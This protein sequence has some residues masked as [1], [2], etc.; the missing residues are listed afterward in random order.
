[1]LYFQ[2]FEFFGHNMEL[3]KHVMSYL[4]PQDLHS[5]ATTSKDML[6]WLTMDMVVRSLLYN[7]TRPYDSVKA[8]YPHMVKRSIYPMSP[9]RVLMICIAKRCEHCPDTKDPQLTNCVRQNFGVRACW[10]CL[11]DKHPD[12][13][14]LDGNPPSQPIISKFWR[15]RESPGQDGY[16]HNQYYLAHRTK[17]YRLFSHPRIL[18]YP[19]GI[20][21]HSLVNGAFIP[22]HDEPDGSY[23]SHDRWELMWNKT[24][25]DAFGDRTGPIF[26]RSMINDV[27]EYMTDEGNDEEID[28]FLD[29]ILPMP[30]NISDYESFTTAYE[31]HVDNADRQ[32]QQRL[33][34]NAEKK[35]Q[36]H[37]SKIDLAVKGIGDIIWHFNERQI[38]KWNKEHYQI[39]FRRVSYTSQSRSFVRA[40]LL[41]EEIH[42][43]NAKWVLTYDTGNLKLDKK[44]HSILGPFLS[45]P[46]LLTEEEAKRLANSLYMHCRSEVFIKSNTKIY[47]INPWNHRV[48][49]RTDYQ[50]DR[51]SRANRYRRRNYKRY[52]YWKDTSME[53]RV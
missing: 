38:I 15:L 19:Y 23:V 28:T 25:F 26:T 17:L 1:M 46:V 52:S 8:L 20:R 44:I 27:I 9:I 12:Q 29:E 21:F 30:D 50:I 47:A 2:A 7:G 51:N 5:A 42:Y 37:R 31:S 16:F 49:I 6:K 18:A 43:E 41:Y 32:E 40:L 13:P 48:T 36:N 39:K 11:N 35:F 24:Q 34:D 33:V 14:I 22:I 53:R 10:D 45:K 3:S 4:L